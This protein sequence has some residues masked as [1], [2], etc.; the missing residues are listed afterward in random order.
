MS[1][2]QKLDTIQNLILF[3]FRYLLFA[4]SMP[5]YDRLIINSEDHLKYTEW[6]YGPPGNGLCLHY[7]LMKISRHL[8]MQ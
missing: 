4:S 1:L 8:M 3:R 7:N 2:T 6:Y 5:R